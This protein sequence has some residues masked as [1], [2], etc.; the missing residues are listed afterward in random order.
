M[1]TNWHRLFGLVLSD[2]FSGSPWKVELEKDLS[3]KQQFLDV[4]ISRR[5]AGEFTGQLPDGLGQ[6]ADHHLL[7]YKS[8]HEP[9]NRVWHLFSGVPETVQFGAKNHR[10]RTSD[11]STILSRLFETYRVE[12]LSMP[13]TIE[14]FREEVALEQL[15]RLTPAERLHGMSISDVIDALSEQEQRALLQKL[16]R[17]IDQDEELS[18]GNAN[19]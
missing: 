7:S 6:L 14:D 10:P 3:L 17:T 12:C 13:Y 15:D 5:A 8:L 2:L 1:Q 18:D 19:S 11:T 4:V 9:H 16:Q